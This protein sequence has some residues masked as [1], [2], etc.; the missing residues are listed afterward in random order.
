MLTTH[1]EGFRILLNSDG[2]REEE[3]KLRFD[4]ETK[5]KMLNPRLRF[6]IA[7]ELA[8]TFFY[9]IAKSTPAIAKKFTSGGGRTELENLERHCNTIAS[10][11]LLPTRLLAS[12]FLRLKFI[13]PESISGLA[14]KAG[15]SLQALLLRL[16]KSDS[17]FIKRYFRGCFVLVDK[18]EGE[19][20]IRAIA[21][22]KSLS[23]A[24]QLSLLR[25]KEIWKLKTHDG[26]ELVPSALPQISVA[27]FAELPKS[28]HLKQ[29]KVCKAEVGSFSSNRQYLLTFEEDSQY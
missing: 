7:H 14:Q 28:K 3:L 18:H 25:A 23:L 16:D 2:G 1:S 13:T 27:T 5:G 8:H 19:L 11:L 12:D 4:T 20:R 9:D 22:P 6:S 29:Y 21:K 26:N 10:H 24:Y 15:V 17:L